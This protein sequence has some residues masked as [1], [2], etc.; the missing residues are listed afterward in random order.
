MRDL[1]KTPWSHQKAIVII[2][3][4]ATVVR[5]LVSVEGFARV[6]RKPR[7]WAGARYLISSGSARRRHC[8]Y[9]RWTAPVTSQSGHCGFASLT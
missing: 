8:D 9:D 6:V 5:K 7:G 1:A 2:T 4:S 3:K